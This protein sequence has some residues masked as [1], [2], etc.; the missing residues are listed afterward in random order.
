VGVRFTVAGN[1]SGTN[2][3]ELYFAPVRA[4]VPLI[5]TRRPIGDSFKP[6]KSMIQ[7]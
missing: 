3:N 6:S 1:E 4:V 7:V 5:G 2:A